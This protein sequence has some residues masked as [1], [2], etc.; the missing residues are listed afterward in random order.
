MKENKN[1]WNRTT[2]TRIV[3]AETFG[4]RKSKTHQ[5]ELSQK[6]PL[7]VSED[8]SRVGRRYSFDDNGGGYLGL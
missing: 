2:T 5:S 8:Y 7:F 1:T 3:E 6:K 4:P